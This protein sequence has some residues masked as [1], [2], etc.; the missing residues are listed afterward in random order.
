MEYTPLEET[1][2]MLYWL[3][4]AGYH[5]ALP[6]YQVTRRGLDSMLVAYTISGRGTLLFRGKKYE[7]L[8]D[9]VFV[10]DCDEFQYYATEADHWEFYWAHFHGGESRQIVRSI[11]AGG[12]P[13]YQPVH[14]MELF[15]KLFILADNPCKKSDILLSAQLSQLLT[16]LLLLAGEYHKTPEAVEQAVLFIEQHSTEEIGLAEIAQAANLSKYHLSRLFKSKIG[17]S[18]YE[19]L[20]NDRLNQAKKLLV[21][22][23]LPVAEIA[24]QCGFAN[25]SGFMR[26]FKKAQSCTPLQY[27]K[28]RG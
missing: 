22:T 12:G 19:Y 5:L 25:Q 9:S 27:R 15:D 4:S 8:P 6:G 14:L 13:V 2:S 16:Q 17:I 23:D 18:P 24:F 26:L 28:L 10:I 1:K 20:L 11:L 3:M 21:T 7:I